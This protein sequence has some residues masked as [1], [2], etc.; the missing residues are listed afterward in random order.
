MGGQVEKVQ[1]SAVQSEETAKKAGMP[2]YVGTARANLAWAAWRQG[3]LAGAQALGLAAMDQWGKVP[4]GHASCAFEWTALLPLMAIA[5]ANRQPDQAIEY[6]RALVDPARMRLPDA[7]ERALQGAIQCGEND[8]ADGTL[9]D[10]IEQ[11]CTYA[12]KTR[13]L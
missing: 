10:Q 5:A 4:A 9:L 8:P 7:L 11:V 6:A 1:Q 13:Y 3:D 2:E 12:Q